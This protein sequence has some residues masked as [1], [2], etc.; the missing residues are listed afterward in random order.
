MFIMFPSYTLNMEV[1]PFWMISC[2]HDYF[3]FK[4]INYM[5]QLYVLNFIL[6]SSE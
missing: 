5:L 3:L 1:I 6:C 4:K 2:Y